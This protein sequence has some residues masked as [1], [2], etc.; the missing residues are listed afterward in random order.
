MAES[1][2]ISLQMAEIVDSIAI[3]V[4]IFTC[5]AMAWLIFR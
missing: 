2:L 1:G 5:A 4:A 3:L